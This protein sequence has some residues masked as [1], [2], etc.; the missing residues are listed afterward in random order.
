MMQ[1]TRQ[2]NN[3]L[4]DET[5]NTKDKKTKER[6]RPD[7]QDVNI[8][9]KTRPNLNPLCILFLYFLVRP[10]YTSPAL[11]CALFSCLLSCFVKIK[12]KTRVDKTRQK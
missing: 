4:H 11:S 1:D 3:M 6:R 5:D 2:D 7:R 8:Q 10:T 12:D 9:D